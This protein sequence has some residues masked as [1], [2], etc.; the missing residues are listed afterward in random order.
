MISTNKKNEIWERIRE[1]SFSIERNMNQL[2]RK[3]TGS[4]FTSLDLTDA[5]MKE[6]VLELQERDSRIWELSFLEP[7]VG[8][9]NFVFSYLKEISKIG[10][11]RQQIIK[12]I[13]NIYVA[14]INNTAL[15][16][17]EELL[18]EFVLLYF[19]IE[20]NKEYF[21]THVGGALLI[22]IAQSQLKYKTIL[23]AFPESIVK[24]GFDIVVT[25]PPYKNMK[26]ERN[27]YT[28]EKEYILDKKKY[29]AVS[30]LVKG[31]FHLSKDGVLNLYK[32][33]VEE[34]IC[35]Y[36]HKESFINLLVPATILSDKTCE[37]LRTAI[38][39][40]MNLI[41]VKIIAEGSGY[42]DAQQ[43]LTTLLIKKGES[44]KQVCVTKNYKLSPQQVTKINIEDIMNNN[45]GNSIFAINN[46]EYAMLKK[47][48]KFPVVK[49]I[50]CIVNSRGEL[51]LTVNKDEIIHDISLYPLIRGRNIAAYFLNGNDISE[52]VCDKFIA[53]SKKSCF[54]NKPRIICQQVVNMHKKRRVKFAYIKGNYVL[55]NSCNFIAVKENLLGI[56]IFMLLGLFNTSII[57]W[58]FKLTSSN[59]HINNYEIDCF[60]IPLGSQYLKEIGRL[61][62]QYLKSKD[63]NL[64]RKIE[65]LAYLAYEIKE[66]HN[67]NAIE[68]HDENKYL[69]S[70]RKELGMVIPDV[71]SKLVENVLNGNASA[72]TLILQNK[73]YIGSLNTRVIEEMTKK[74]LKLSR[75][76][77]LNHTT[78][79][80]SSLD[81]EMISTVPQGGSWKDIPIR[82]VNKSQRL[83]RITKTGGRTTLYGRIDYQ[84]PAYTITTY[85]NRPGNGTY[86]HPV[87]ERVL[88]VREAARFQSFPD[89]Y[90]FCGNKTDMLKEV[91]NAVPVVLAYNIA[92]EII[93]QTGC[94]TSVDLFSGA[95][96]M[97]YGFKLAGIKA[98]IAN[99]LETS[100]CITLKVNSPEI[101]VICGDITNDSLKEIIIETGVKAEADIICGGPPCQGFSLAGF[102]SVKDSRNKLFRDFVDVV[103]GVKPKIIVFENVEGILSYQNGETYRNIIELFAE[104]GYNTEGRKLM[105]TDYGVP[106][107]RKRVII[108]C[109]RKDMKIMPSALFPKAIT[110][111][112]K[113][114]INAYDTI[115]DLENVKC[116][117]DAKYNSK[118]S[119]PIIK[120]F[121]G[122][123]SL[124]EYVEMLQYQQINEN[125]NLTEATK[126]SLIKQKAPSH[127]EISL[128]DNL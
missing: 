67:T 34:I 71:D 104:L 64:L 40:E 48:R 89:N 122:K 99:D 29:A 86:V 125:N 66:F 62:K 95:G 39:S 120:Y 2:D 3:R 63:E 44:T 75:G 88:S 8:N 73:S 20:L 121:R 55:G 92:K 108:L 80:L 53:S 91:G 98:A 23:E 36:S 47:L 109:T 77:I 33:F 96:G 1:S 37:K 81:L 93:A 60:P 59:N 51:D 79:K 17:Y 42:I 115:Y 68:L 30:E 32:L 18:T 26:A 112:K 21:K 90:L 49:D 43:A 22:D 45:T 58:L 110:Q 118:F 76:E 25:N 12:L 102:R 78:F 74:Y 56:D 85:F 126:K 61:A 84:K 24:N 83:L 54:I 103:S 123:I 41:S 35:K 69:E 87:H 52:Y 114:Q 127:R 116:G 28:N 6:L 101:P 124:P 57:D 94:H 11:T 7:C 4:Y 105:A 14:D 117:E 16:K 19:N 97:T 38:L 15:K 46:A 50:S 13:N 128:F 106:Q 82:T 72:T 100:A 111:N 107:R 27:Q 113:L 119:S 10:F 70:F 31:T 5:M 65:E 9:G